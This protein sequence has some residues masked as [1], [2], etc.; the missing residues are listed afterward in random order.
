M[1]EIRIITPTT[2]EHVAGFNRCV[3]AVARER[4]YLGMLKAPPLDVSRA[5]VQSVLEGGGVCLLAWTP[6]MGS[7]AGATSSAGG[8]RGSGTG[9]GWVSGCCPGRAAP[10]WAGD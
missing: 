5:F 4:R 9:G 8:R 2:D 1:D 6:R 3:D 7:S 10:G